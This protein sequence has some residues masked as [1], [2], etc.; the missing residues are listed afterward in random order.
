MNNESNLKPRRRLAPFAVGMDYIGVG[1]TKA[2]ELIASGEIVAVKMGGRT[3]I[4]LDSVDKFH[5]GLPPL[6]PE[7]AS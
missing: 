4:D 3:M 6:V 7:K 5:A 2:Y 1:R